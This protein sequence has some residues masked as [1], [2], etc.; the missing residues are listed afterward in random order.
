MKV[1]EIKRAKSRKWERVQ[2]QSMKA[3]SDWSKLND[4]VDWRMVGMMSRAE[5]LDSKTLPIVGVI[6][7][8]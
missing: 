4:I 6:S 7:Q 5:T 2:A 1:F 3:L 8:E